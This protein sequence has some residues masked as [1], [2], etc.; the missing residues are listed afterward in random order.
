[1][2][3]VSIF[4]IAMLLALSLVFVGGMRVAPVE[5]G[6]PGTSP[7]LM[8][9]MPVVDG[10][11]YFKEKDDDEDDDEDDEEDDDKEDLTA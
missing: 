7:Q 10:D 8:T 9:E 6:H 5:A 1:M 2:K 4:V 3:N 11:L